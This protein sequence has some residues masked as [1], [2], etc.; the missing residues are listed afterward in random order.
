MTVPQGQKIRVSA[1]LLRKAV[2]FFDRLTGTLEPLHREITLYS[3]RTLAM[4]ASDGCLVAE[5]ALPWMKVDLGKRVLT[6][7]LD[8][9]KAF[10][11]QAE[12]EVELLIGRN[13][14]LTHGK[15]V[16]T[17]ET[18]KR[19]YL[20]EWP[21]AEELAEIP[22]QRLRSVLDFAS[23]HLTDADSVE[24]GTWQ[25]KLYAAGFTDGH[26]AAALTPLEVKRGFSVLLPYA[27][28]RHLVKCL[29][30][31]KREML[32]L[33]LPDGAPVLR[34]GPLRIALLGRA[35]VKDLQGAL[36][37]L[38]GE[39]GPP[40]WVIRAPELRKLASRAARMQRNGASVASLR[41]HPNRVE[42]VVESEHGPYRSFEEVLMT[43]NPV[44]CDVRVR[45]ER[46]NS[47]LARF[48]Q[49]RVVLHWTGRGLLITDG[50][51]RSVLL[52]V[53][54]SD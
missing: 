11:R 5:L 40:L 54:P 15:D 18:R 46:L 33:E 10:L 12:G 31:V 1:E 13:L 35:G 9:L 29:E 6:V 45:M 17:L 44:R 24:L 43:K 49:G 42:A 52:S 23:V 16:L 19:G 22:C 51:A 36:E 25:G 3:P 37:F 20:P 50:R 38:F 34:G 30:L 2:E 48:G 27:S 28:A 8:P 41:L 39:H 26:L 14:R 21:R 7:S 47:L 53:K 4:R 32:T